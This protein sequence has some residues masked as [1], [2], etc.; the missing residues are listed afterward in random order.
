MASVGL[1][2][3]RW[4]SR[5][6]KFINGTEGIFALIFYVYSIFYRTRPHKFAN[7]HVLDSW[8]ISIPAN[9]LIRKGAGTPSREI[10]HS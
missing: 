3:Y 4:H 6:W 2:F 1:R 9:V 5:I 8:Y 7:V 10:K